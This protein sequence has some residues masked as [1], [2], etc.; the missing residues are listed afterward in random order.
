MKNQKYWYYLD[1]LR[2]GRIIDLTHTFD[3]TTPHYD[4]FPP[5]NIRDVFTLEEHGVWSQEYCVVGQW[6]THFDPP[7]HLARGVRTLD[8]IPVDQLILPLVVIDV[9]EKIIDNPDYMLSIDDIQEW[10][11]QYDEIP[12]GSFVAMRTDWGHRWPNN[13][14]I[15][16]Y[17]TEGIAHWPGW[18]LEVLQFLFTKKS[19]TAI[20]H[21]TIGTDGGIK[22]SEANFE[23]QRWLSQQDHFQVELLTNLD[24]LSC[25]GS[26]IIIG[27]PKLKG[28]S[29]FPVRA[30]AI[31]PELNLN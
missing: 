5:M 3:P 7:A 23:G 11:S 8:Q 6:G 16:N 19:I 9:H 26:I 29:G 17:D 21:E 22:T 27:F 28:G 12:K 13:N 25:T 18:S 24:K 20:G 15:Q 30:Y 1:E 4:G 31:S 10:E 14:A 2:K